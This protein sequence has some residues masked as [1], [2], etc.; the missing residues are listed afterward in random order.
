MRVAPSRRRG[1]SQSLLY[2]P[3]DEFVRRRMRE[4]GD[5]YGWYQVADPESTVPVVELLMSLESETDTIPE[6]IGSVA[7]RIRKI[8]PPTVHSPQDDRRRA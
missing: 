2:G 1:S 5:V 7:I 6:T 3:V 8:S 4:V